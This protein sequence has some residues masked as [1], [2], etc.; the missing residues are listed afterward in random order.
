MELCIFPELQ[1]FWM[2]GRCLD[3]FGIENGMIESRDNLGIL[4]GTMKYFSM[5]VMYMYEGTIW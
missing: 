3:N 1:N 5:G 4:H 2:S